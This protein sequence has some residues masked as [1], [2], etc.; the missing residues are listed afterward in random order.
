MNSNGMGSLTKFQID[1]IE[2]LASRKD[3]DKHMLVARSNGREITFTSAESKVN[4][5]NKQEIP[6]E[7]SD[8]AA[9]VLCL[10]DRKVSPKFALKLIKA[11]QERDNQ[12]VNPQDMLLLI[13]HVD[14]T[15]LKSDGSTSRP[16]SAEDHRSS[17]NTLH[18]DWGS[19][20]SLDSG[21]DGSVFGSTESI[22]ENADFLRD[23][24]TSPLSEKVTELI[25]KE[26]YIGAHEK[27]RQESH[28]A[29]KGN[30][31]TDG[32]WK[33]FGYGDEKVG[34][35]P[36]P[37]KT[38]LTI[39][40]NYIPANR[41]YMTNHN[42]VAIQAPQKNFG[43]DIW[44]AALDSDSKC[45]VI[46]D[47]TGEKDKIDKKG[48]ILE[49]YYP[50]GEKDPKTGK[51]KLE[52]NLD[53]GINVKFKSRSQGDGYTKNIYVV[54]D[55]LSGKTSELRRYHYSSWPDHGVPIGKN[56]KD[57]LLKFVE[58]LRYHQNK[59]V[60]SSNTMV[61]CVAGVGRTGT[62]IVLNEIYQDILSGKYENKKELDQAVFK[63]IQQG[64]NDRG[65]A[66]VQKGEQIQFIME[67]VH[68]WHE[69]WQS[70][71]NIIPEI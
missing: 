31:I 24:A 19:T 14:D 40:G 57:S 59:S 48:G 13:D 42:Y 12:F 27:M 55:T 70:G 39:D 35:V 9:K 8:L 21:Y 44:R 65:P 2:G 32:R 49:S 53:N 16:D 33:R 43:A 46:C 36:L 60:Y 20:T 56:S 1:Q 34:F 61:H 5:E 62:L 71:E 38:A 64:R 37:K 47:L 69:Q 67:T 11:Y 63:A 41:I 25:D 66:F 6:V 18:S 7:G 52:I 22:Y 3:S 23:R 17:S 15:Y 51:Y 68:T 50:T 10:K 54:T 28:E 45:S 29:I 58:A 30:H 4:P 26:D